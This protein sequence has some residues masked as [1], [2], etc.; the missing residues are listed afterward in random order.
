MILLHC[1]CRAVVGIERNCTHI[2]FQINFRKVR[3]LF[4]RAKH[5]VAIDAWL[6]KEQAS[7]G[8]LA[9]R[10]PRGYIH[11]GEENGLEGPLLAYLFNNAL[12]SFLRKGAKVLAVCGR[13]SLA[14]GGRP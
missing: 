2:H 6:E 11:V 3:K 14:P 4:F 5:L 12:H 9:V 7:S 8:T 1:F 10:F 13:G